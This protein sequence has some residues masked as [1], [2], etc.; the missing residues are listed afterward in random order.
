[1]IAA[2]Q[3]LVQTRGKNFLVLDVHGVGYR[4]FVP[5]SL[6]VTTK[7]GATLTLWTHTHVREEA[8]E[9]YG[10]AESDA[11][12]LFEQLLGVSGVGPKTALGVLS[13]ASPRE[14]RQAIASG[15]AS[16]LT[17]VSGIGKKTAERIVVELKEKTGLADGGDV[18]EVG[19]AIDALV[20]LGYSEQQA[21]DAVRA[22]QGKQKGNADVQTIVKAAL[23]VRG[24]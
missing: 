3:G 6:L 19:E 1:M 4:V 11:L 15:D 7:D 16:V 2:L 22:V 24:T 10:F 20:G 5:P 13:I 21:R 23:K 9:L 18:G 17:K 12:A 14:I 8:L